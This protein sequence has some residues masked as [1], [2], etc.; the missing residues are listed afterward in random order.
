LLKKVSRALALLI[1]PFIASLL[2]RL[3]YVTNKK[4]FHVPETIGDEPAIF[5]CWHG[6]LLMLPYV[7]K[8]YRKTPNAK[9]LIS[10]HF[11]GK[12]ISKTITYFG[13]GTI[14]GS[15]NRNAARVL[16]QAMKSLKAGFDIGITPDGP[17]GP[18]HEVADGIIIM[19]QKTKTK[20]VL[21]KIVPTKFWQ[22]NSW[23]KF[24][25]PKPFGILNYYATS[26]I[27]ITG[28]E[29]EKARALIKKELEKH[30]I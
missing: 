11:D 2:I 30:E 16:I 12:L 8:F 6:E 3:I 22:L 5:A 7:Y 14:A 26:P 23:D 10:P 24:I 9:V 15:S 21:V 29:L 1:L 13:L 20:V 28:M 27:N 25:I 4:V 17:K 19:A 18:R